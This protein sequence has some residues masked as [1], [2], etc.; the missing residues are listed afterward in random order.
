MGGATSSIEGFLAD[1]LT[2]IFSKIDRETTREGL[3]DLHL[4]I[5]GNATSV[6]SNL[7]GGRHLHLALMMTASEYRI[8]T[9]FVFVP[10]HN[11]GGYPQSTGN[12]KKFRQNQVFFRKYIAMDGAL[13]KQIVMVV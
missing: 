2:P 6:A 7:G 1:F 11:P 12:A 8:Q 9:G 5:S 4:L 13:K 3:I 10:L